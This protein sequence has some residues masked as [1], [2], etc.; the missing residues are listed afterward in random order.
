MMTDLDYDFI[1]KLAAG[2]SAI[3][4]ENGKQCLVETRLAPLLRQ[5][6]LISI[7]ELRREAVI[8]NLNGQS[9]KART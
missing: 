4:L 3:V 7:T 1:R 5:R 9:T 8:Q 6:E 2:R